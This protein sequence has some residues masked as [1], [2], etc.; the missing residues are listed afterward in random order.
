[1]LQQHQFFE[2]S[3]DRWPD[4]WAVDYHGQRLSYR[5]LGK[6]PDVRPAI[7][8]SSPEDLAYIIFTS[9]STGNP[10]G[11]M[12]LHRNTSL[13]LEACAGFFE[14]ARGSRFAHFSDFTFDPSIFDMFHCW[15]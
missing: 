9:G 1:M 12:V 6:M 11:V 15:H 13:F 14:I 7:E 4:Q 2:A 5:E 8:G 3:A 10:K